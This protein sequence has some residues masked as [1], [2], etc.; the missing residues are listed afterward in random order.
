MENKHEICKRLLRTLKSTNDFK[1]V[2]KI[3]YFY[4]S[5]KE[6]YVIVWYEVHRNWEKQK[7]DVSKHSGYSMILE[8]LNH[9][10]LH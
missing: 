2:M 5:P 4:E 6:Q 8:I 10:Y 1:N 3:E 9:I 7:I